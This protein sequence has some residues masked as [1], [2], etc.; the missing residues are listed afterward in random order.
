MKKRLLCLPLLALMALSATAC[1]SKKKSDSQSSSVEPA[2]A[3]SSIDD[4]SATPAPAS[5]SSAP[6][7][8]K[9][10]FVPDG[11]EYV[12]PD[13]VELTDEGLAQHMADAYAYCEDLV[14]QGSVLFKNS[15]ENGDPVLPLK[16]SERKITLFGR[17]SRN[18][19]YR[20]GAGGAAPN[21]D[22]N[23]PLLNKCFENCGFEVNNTVFNLYTQAS[24]EGGSAEMTNPQGNIEAS[25]SIYT[26]AVKNT[27]G[28]YNDAAIVVFVRVG[29]E[30]KDPNAGALDLKDNEKALL[31]MIKDSGE[32]DKTIVLINGPLA[33]SM[34]WVNDPQ[35]GVDA[36]LFMGVPGYYGAEG[37][38]HV[39]TGEDDNG[40]PVNPS[41]HA[42]DTF[43]NSA[44]SSAAYQN[45][46][47]GPIAYLEGIYV[48]YKYYETRYEDLVLG[49]GNADGEN[50]VY[51]SSDN[52]WNYAEEMGYP[53]GF[54][55]SYT[56][57]EQKLLNVEYNEETDQIEAQIEIENTG[58]LDGRAVAQLYVSAPYTDFDKDNGLG[59]SAVAIMAYDKIMV[60]AHQ[61]KNIQ[62]SFDRYF[63]CTYDYKVNKTYILEEGD[64]YFGLGNGAHEALNNILSVKEPN[65]SLYDHNGED[66]EGNPDA[67]KMLHIDEDLETYKKSHYNDEEVTNQFD[68]ADCN[69][70]ANEN[71]MEEATYLDRQDWNGTWPSKINPKVNLGPETSNNKNGGL[72]NGQKNSQQ[73][74]TQ[75][76]SDQYTGGDG[77]DY[78][79]PYIDDNGEESLI[80]F[81]DM[82]G[83]P[84]KGIVEEGRFEGMEGAD[85]WDAFVK[86]MTLD[87]LL[88]STT[89][90]RGILDVGKVMKRGNS[91][92]E[93]PEG[94]LGKY[95]Y[96]EGEK[97]WA[98]GFPTGPTYTGT[99]DPKMQKRYGRMFGRDALFA[100]IS[101]V[102]A[103]GANI[104]RTPYGS[105]AS[106][107]MSEDAIVNYN[108]AANI[109]SEARKEGLI[110]NI[111]HCMLNNQETGR[112]GIETYCNEQ[113][114][115]EIY[116]KPFEG[117]LTKGNGLGIMTSYN[118]I[119][120]RYAAVHE[121][122][123][124][125]V[126][127]REWGYQGL[128]IDDGL[129]IS[130]GSSYQYSPAM[131]HAGTNLFCLNGN[132]GGEIKNWVTQH[133]DGTILKDLQESN[134]YIM[135]ALTHS[136]LA[137]FDKFANFEPI[138]SEDFPEVIKEKARSEYNFSSS[139]LSGLSFSA[140]RNGHE[141]VYRFEGKYSEGYQGQYNTYDST[142][143]LWDDGLFV[144]KANSTTFKGYWYNSS[145]R[146]GQD[147]DGN[148][149]CDCLVMYSNAS[150]Y[151][152]IITS[153][154]AVGQRQAYI[155]L[156][157]G[158]G[159]GRSVVVTGYAQYN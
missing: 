124:K 75:D 63:L 89:D 94:L 16:S 126:I 70:W 85:V 2:P 47:N 132:S 119:G 81:N 6:S 27:F 120:A 66:Y 20:S 58:D 117:A 45:F 50:G 40:D 62:L 39:L 149:I 138:E 55:L 140:T 102:N 141:L 159:E 137:G 128:I 92:A 29:T 65:V 90:V 21:I 134:K 143:Y 17:A 33:M 8:S 145:L 56:T 154:V 69:Y 32:F 152:T 87:D 67:V 42:P 99:F 71:G 146:D 51:C 36:C 54:G 114:I 48:G 151:E 12:E 108:V 95:Q 49:Q 100:G 26:D 53:F 41:G 127:R 28:D 68:D 46:G 72:T 150:R 121:P 131:V 13:P 61:K 107:Y 84:L 78:N 83:V 79:V 11:D 147:A 35:Y 23:A 73:Y 52:I 43:A 76:T 136:S 24:R 105:R 74:Y 129:S 111:K 157:P 118:R 37:I 156:N 155:F 5:S 101:C 1:G 135:Y 19:Y 116:L 109:V 7:S 38:V 4:S 18:L 106:E 112:Q 10:P 115:R 59:K 104:N 93:G 113:A 123:M 31:K 144:G 133:N 86:Q 103:V 30:D 110:M 3:S 91:V 9:T 82:V 88:I 98:T 96:G 97:Q 148:D 44:S 60:P 64:Y 158:W 25:P 80:T 130:N 57:F 139:E 125:E 153:P 22:V 122:M 142:I 15:D 34:D 77:V 14:E